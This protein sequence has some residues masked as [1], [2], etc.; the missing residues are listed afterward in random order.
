MS[1]LQPFQIDENTIIYVEASDDITT[2]TIVLEPEETT[3][4]A[5]GIPFNAREQI[6]QNFQA[7]ETT[8]KIY[9]QYTLNA[10]RA[11]SL[12][13]VKNV[14]LEFG[15]NV[16]GE[17]GIPYIASG[18]VGCNIKVTVECEFPR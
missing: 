7:I 10:F 17:G 11:S 3:R 9:T 16:S 4:T 2:S 15:V 18:T 14:K 8:I 13:E 12:P 5:K 1:R 6:V